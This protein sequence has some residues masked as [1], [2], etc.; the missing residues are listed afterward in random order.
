MTLELPVV[1]AIYRVQVIH[2]L[3]WRHPS[4]PDFEVWSA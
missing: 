2:I 4:V 1:L 3:L